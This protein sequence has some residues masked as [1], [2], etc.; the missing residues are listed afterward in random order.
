MIALQLPATTHRSRKSGGVPV[1][2]PVTTNLSTLQKLTE[3]LAGLI[4]SG[5][6]D[7]DPFHFGEEP[8]IGMGKITPERD[9]YELELTRLFLASNKPILGICRGMQVLNIVAGE[10]Y[11]KIFILKFIIPYSNMLRKLPNFILLMG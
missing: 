4:L 11:G 3:N 10:Q 7:L 5:G 1:I 9:Y 6:G 2:I 8:V